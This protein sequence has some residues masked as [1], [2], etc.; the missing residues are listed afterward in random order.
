MAWRNA[1][2]CIGRL[3]WHRLHVRDRRA[4]ARARP[5]S[6]HECV[7]HLR[8]ATRGG[9]IRSTITVF[10]PD[11]PGQPG[12]RIHNDQLVRYAGHRTSTGGVRG[13]RG[14]VELTDHALALGWQRPTRPAASTC[15]RC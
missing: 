13:D 4:R 3:Y 9:R 5:T 1:A 2:R 8:E 7:A 15:C 10:A 12:P 6:P 14:Q 11:R